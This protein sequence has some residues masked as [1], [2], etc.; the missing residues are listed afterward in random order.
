M[1]KLNRPLEWMGYQ[2]NE[3]VAPDLSTLSAAELEA[4]AGTTA[5]TILNAA[6]AREAEA[7][8]RSQEMLQSAITESDRLRSDAEASASATLKAA[9]KSATS[10][11]ESANINAEKSLK[12]VER[13]AT[14]ILADAN[15]Q[16]DELLKRANAEASQMRITVERGLKDASHQMTSAIAKFTDGVDGQLQLLR[17]VTLK[18]SRIESELL[19]ARD[20]VAELG[21]AL[22]SSDSQDSQ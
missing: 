20:A 8:R 3:P 22:F 1:A 7:E 21:A 13:Q 6:H 14:Q 11:I 5:V 10:L 12:S 18:A 16:A 15:K 9:Q 4:L 2:E 17:Q 19:T